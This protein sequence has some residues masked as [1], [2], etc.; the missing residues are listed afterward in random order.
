M[1]FAVVAMVAIMASCGSKKATE[2]V[3]VDSVE[4][5]EADTTAAAEAVEV[6][7][8]ASEVAAQ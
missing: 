2:E 6:D 7:S 8:S 3:A 5:V 1:M 4:V